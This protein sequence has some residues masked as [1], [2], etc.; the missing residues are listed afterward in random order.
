MVN[1]IL[2]AILIAT[3]VYLAISG[4]DSIKEYVCGRT[5]IVM[6]EKYVYP[7]FNDP[8]LVELKEFLENDDTDKLQYN[9]YN[10]TCQNFAITLVGRLY[11]KRIFSCPAIVGFSNGIRHMVVAVKTRDNGIV[12][13]EPQNDMII[14]NITKHTCHD[15][16]IECP[17]NVYVSY[18]FDCFKGGSHG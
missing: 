2:L 14:L 16:S 17:S 6:N 18:V 15:F 1:K 4:M 5:V 12:Y 3:L 8:S 11:Q 9:I 13:V 10:F 7:E